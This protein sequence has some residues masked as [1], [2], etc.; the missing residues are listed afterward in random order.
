MDTLLNNLLKPYEDDVNIPEIQQ[1]I[2]VNGDGFISFQEFYAT[3][4]ADAILQ[5]LFT[6]SFAPVEA[7]DVKKAMIQHTESIPVPPPQDM[8]KEEKISTGVCA[9]CSL[10]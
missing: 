10:L 2:D 1:K 5:S 3:M 8:K 9:N 4:Q 6:Q 7:G